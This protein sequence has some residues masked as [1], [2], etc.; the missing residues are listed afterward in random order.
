MTIADILF[1]LK[2]CVS[3]K[4]YNCQSCGPSTENESEIDQPEAVCP[5]FILGIVDQNNLIFK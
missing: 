5:L 1:T 3:R 2:K 4:V